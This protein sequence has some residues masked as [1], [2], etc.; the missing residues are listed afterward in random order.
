MSP[1]WS[2]AAT[3]GGLLLAVVLFAFCYVD[4]RRGVLVFT[5]LGCIRGVQ[6]GA[7]SGRETT[8]GLRMVEVLATALIAA[9]LLRVAQAHSGAIRR[10]SFN[11]PL[12]LLLPA[13]IVSLL[14]SFAWFD[15]TVPLQNI[16]LAVSLGQILLILWPIG[17]Y[18][19][20]ASSIR[21]DRAIVA[22]R[23]L[24]VA[25][26]IPSIALV[27]APPSV[28]RYLE[29]STTFALPASSLCF[30][31]FFHTRGLPRKLGLLVITVAPVVYGFA[32]GKA[33]YYAYV[34]VSSTV[35]AYL[36]APRLV[37]AAA[38]VAFAA[39]VVLVPLLSGALMPGFLERVIATEQSQQSLGG[40]GGREQLIADGLGIWL[41]HPVFG[42]G[43]G[44][45]YPYMLRYSTVGTPHNQYVNVLME[46][47]VI[48]LAC[49]LLFAF[50]AIRTGLAV[51]RR[52]REPLHQ[53]VALGWLGLFAAM[54]VGGLFG[55]FMLPSI[56]NSGLELFAL[57]YVQWILLGVMVS[58]G[59]LERGRTAAV[60]PR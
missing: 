48:G 29:W 47:G 44:N 21:D 14:V 20:V 49:F 36:K 26:A 41:R 5:A 4:M 13:S 2:S 27:A 38:P 31:E 60:T 34:V 39:Y 18:M 59:A 58:I 10:V 40:H 33:F 51:W 25:L 6:V 19:V 55:D 1:S 28:A 56:R 57:F 30:A 8:Q 54:L 35:I 45:N 32:S 11:T 50:R 37:L 53:K 12:F 24:I 7:F 9:W 15:P 22:V 17:T 46:L 23:N 52:S 3:I 42:V 43:P 16:N